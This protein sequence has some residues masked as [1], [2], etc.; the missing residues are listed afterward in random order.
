M[1]DPVETLRAQADQYDAYANAKSVKFAER[2]R[3]R[4]HAAELRASA[5]RLAAS[6][7]Q[8]ASNG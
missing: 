6:T 1:D 4:R 5:D 8:E 7:I 2:Q 3:Y